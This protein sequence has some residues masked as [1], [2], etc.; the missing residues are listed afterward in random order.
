MSGLL[1]ACRPSGTWS[2]QGSNQELGLRPLLGP[3]PGPCPTDH[4]QTH[5]KGGQSQAVSSLLSMVQTEQKPAPDLVVDRD[6]R[7]LGLSKGGG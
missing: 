6:P 4:P 1:L 2:L 5:L 3:L 7:H